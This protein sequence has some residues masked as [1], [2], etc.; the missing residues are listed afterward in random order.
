MRRK[1]FDGTLGSRVPTAGTIVDEFQD[2]ARLIDM[3]RLC[4]NCLIPTDDGNFCGRTC[5]ET[6]HG[7]DSYGKDY[8][9][10]RMGDKL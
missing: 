10:D 3:H 2:T 4:P 5:Y 7:E 6:Y 1:L 8:Y 9:D